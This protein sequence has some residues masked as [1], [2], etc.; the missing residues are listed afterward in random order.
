MFFELQL[1]A[2]VFGRIVRNRLRAMD[3]CFDREVPN[4]GHPDQLMAIDQIVI[5][6]ATEVQRELSVEYRDEY[7][8]A[9]NHLFFAGFDPASTQLVGFISS[10]GNMYDDHVPYLQVKQEVHVMLVPVAGLTASGPNPSLARDVRIDLVYNVHS[11]CAN[12]TQGGG[13]V[14]LSYKLAYVDFSASAPSAIEREL[15]SA[16]VA[17]IELPPSTVDLG[18]M[19]RILGRPIGAVNCGIAC[20]PHGTRVALRADFLPFDRNVRASVNPDFFILG[21][22]D[23]LV[24]P[25][26]DRVPNQKDWATLIDANVLI[27]Q[28]VPGVRD[29]LHDRPK[30]KVLAEPSGRWDAANVALQVAAHIRLLG[31]CPGFVDDINLDVRVHLDSRF[32]V[33]LGT[34]DLK[35]GHYLSRQFTNKA[36]RNGCAITGALLYPIFGAYLVADKTIG[37]SD[38]LEG[39]ALGPLFDYI[40]LLGVI[41]KKKLEKDISSHLGSTCSKVND[42]EYQCVSTPILRT[43]FVPRQL[44]RLSLERASGVPKGLVLSGSITGL[45][46]YTLGP[47][48]SIQSSQFAWTVTGGCNRNRDGGG[49][50]RAANT[51]GIYIDNSVQPVN[52]LYA[53]IFAVRILADPLNVFAVTEVTDVSVTIEATVT[54]AYAAA[55]YDC[56]IRLVT[57]RGVRNINLGQAHARTADE[58][59]DIEEQL[60]QW[61]KL[62]RTI[63]R[64][65]LPLD[66]LFK[67]PHCRPAPV[68][69]FGTDRWLLFRSLDF[70]GLP[71]NAELLLRNTATTLPE[72]SATAS[73]DGTASL[74][75]L[76]ELP[77]PVIRTSLCLDLRNGPHAKSSSVD[78]QQILYAHRSDIAVSA[79]PRRLQLI[80]SP[81][82]GQQLEF[83]A[84]ATLH[85]W[86]LSTPQLPTQLDQSPSTAEFESDEQHPAIHREA[87]HD[88]ESPSTRSASTLSTNFTVEGAMPQRS[89]TRPVPE[90]PAFLDNLFVEHL[91]ELSVVRI[92]EAVMTGNWNGAFCL[93]YQRARHRR[94]NEPNALPD[95]GARLRPTPRSR[96]GSASASAMAAAVGIA[97]NNEGAA[98]EC[99]WN[100]RPYR[101][102][103]SGKWHLQGCRNASTTA[104]IA[105]GNRMSP[106]NGN[107]VDWQLIQCA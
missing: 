92:Y 85:T 53:H 104:P 10:T 76:T 89:Q 3:L 34:H 18:A 33:P 57:N 31:A 30:T 43:E 86:D 91:P 16:F 101:Q 71:P 5:G 29:A 107:A 46:E 12:R 15:I 61:Q 27:S 45:N 98:R 13:P 26:S 102:Y 105:R 58:D 20:D 35:V 7:D 8:A 49:S 66:E 38:Y 84:G 21:P 103:L 51:A 24:D 44:S 1:S 47:I 73:M 48:N 90:C 69:L 19:T 93:Q 67:V 83:V 65:T 95:S 37:L 87:Q 78:R 80:G 64:T 25:E 59:T 62:C 22:D 75:I 52:T 36:Q 28:A 77:A 106:Y 79:G 42:W 14:T 94:P 99:S 97:A 4:L 32:S 63:T 100:Y 11:S 17:G 40:Q 56:I 82:G 9:G 88:N 2:A 70:T 68:E 23:L 81:T 96:S 72:A 6:D 54:D 60:R 55:P 74:R 39:I 41:D 50:F